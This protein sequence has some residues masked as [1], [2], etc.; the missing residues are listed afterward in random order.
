M[1][2]RDLTKNEASI[3]PDLGSTIKIAKPKVKVA[4][5]NAYEN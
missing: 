3:L 1:Y 5:V 2:R 4:E